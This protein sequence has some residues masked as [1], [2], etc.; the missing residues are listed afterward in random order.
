MKKILITGSG[1]GLGKMAAIRLSKR[2]HMVYAKTHYQEEA[3]YLNNYAKENNLNLEAFKLDILLKEDKN[4][5]LKYD[6]D[7]Y[8][9][10]AAIG[11][12]GSVSEVNID[13]I[14]N[15]F[16]T[17]VFC[18]IELAQIVIKKMIDNNI[19][20]R[21]I[22]LSSLC[23]RIP[24]PFLSPYCSSKFALESFVQC[25]RNEMK[26]VP[27]PKI[28]VCIIEPGAYATGFNKINTDKKYEWMKKESYF[29]D[30]YDELK[31]KEI[32]LWN[33]IELKNFNS[34]INKYIR[35]VESNKVKLRYTAP[36]YQAFFVWISRVF[37]F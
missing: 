26:L 22:F 35:T 20:G 36:K 10:N 17:N 9:A 5:I 18:N 8:I 11:D 27:G 14:K 30:I 24:M 32:K 6:I 28:E 1:S 4:L 21:L 31:T 29:K 7:T 37:G 13:R 15:V 23:G 33:L 3:D 16:E 12:S 25:L 19:K 34:V 2:G